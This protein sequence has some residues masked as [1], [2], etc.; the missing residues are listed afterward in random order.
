MPAVKSAVM[1]DCFS[2]RTTLK[3]ITIQEL[4]TGVKTLFAVIIQHRV[5]DDNLKTQIKN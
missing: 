4:H 2:L 5:I 1:Y 3:A